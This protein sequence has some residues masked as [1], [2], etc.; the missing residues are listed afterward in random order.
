MKSLSLIFSAVLL[1]VLA[2]GCKT[3]T[4][5]SINPVTGQ[6][7]TITQKVPDVAQ[8]QTI[9]KSAA[10]IGTQVWLNGLPPSVP[11]HPADRTKFLLVRNSLQTL[12]AAGNFNATALTAALQSL[13]VTQLQG[14]SGTLIVG[15]AVILWDQYG[16]QLASL[17]KAQVFNTYV[18]PVAQ[19]ILD[20]LNMALGPN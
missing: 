9:A 7:N 8:M 17:D 4:Y 15:E 2:S 16:Q 20:G 6:T 13:P 11:G 14:P 12:I 10:Y 19:S 18:L 5:S 1:L 3:A